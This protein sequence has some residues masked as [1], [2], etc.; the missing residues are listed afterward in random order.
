MEILHYSP[1][2][3]RD[4]KEV[5]QSVGERACRTEQAD[6]TQWIPHLERALT[7]LHTKKLPANCFTF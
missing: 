4:L 2:A 3:V 7:V 6:G 1:K 5:A